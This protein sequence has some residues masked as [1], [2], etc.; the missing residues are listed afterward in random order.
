MI[1]LT[2]KTLIS[3]VVRLNASNGKLGKELLSE[4]D[5]T[6]VV[7]AR[8]LFSLVRLANQK[9]DGGIIGGLWNAG[10][11]FVNF[12]GGLFNGLKFSAS[13]IWDLFRGGLTALKA[14][15]WNASDEALQQMVEGQN[16]G[17]ASTWGGVV[18]KGLGWFA[19]IGIGYGI[20]FICP[21]IGGAALANSVALAASKE[22]LQEI[23]GSLGGALRQTAQTI[24]SNLLISGYINFRKM[25]KNA[26]RGLLEGI[27]GKDTADF[28]QNT[29]GNKG[30]INYSF[31]YQM[32]E[33]IESIDNKYL[34]AFLESMFEEAWDSFTEAGFVIA[35]EI[36]NAYSQSKLEKKQEL[37]TERSVVVYPDREEKSEALTFVDTPQKLLKPAV[38][39][40][41]N[42]HRLIRNRDIGLVMGLPVEEYTRA[43]QQ[44]LKLV[45]NLFSVKQ[46]PF[47]KRTTDN[48]AWVTISIPDVKRSMLD[49]EKIKLAVGGANGY[50]WGRFCAIAMLDTGRK[51]TCYASTAPEAEN[52][53][54][55]LLTLTEGKLQTLNIIEETKAGVRTTRRKLA[56]QPTQVYPAYFTILNWK[57]TTDPNAGR[58]TKKGQYRQSK[59]RVDLWTPTEP[60]NAKT[61]IREILTLGS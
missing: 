15:D 17:L 41:L 20:S 38:Q 32:D 16:V 2:V 26:P 28:I 18:G 13:A 43:K 35:A 58:A 46:P 11:A 45:I 10:K 14:F 12:I 33:F 53:V 30:G 36:D 37:G 55:R 23:T 48:F 49:W 4:A 52:L 21:V 29:W 60:K 31:N 1:G 56:K 59:G 19:A 25:L 27:Y 8:K 61:I 6:L 47:F 22:A 40:A 42:Q 57:E 9:T 5:G 24:G 54:E 51:I 3:R 7:K 44:S 34:K 39:T 50:T